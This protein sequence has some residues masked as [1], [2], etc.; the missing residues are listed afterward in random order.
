MKVTIRTNGTIKCEEDGKDGFEI[1]CKDAIFDTHMDYDRTRAML[2]QP[3]TDIVLNVIE[4]P[5]E[6]AFY[7]SKKIMESFK[8]LAVELYNKLDK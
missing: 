7:C 6:P 2:G 8:N 1:H 3:L 4:T 5:E